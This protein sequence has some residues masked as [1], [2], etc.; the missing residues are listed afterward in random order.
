LE[1]CKIWILKNQTNIEIPRNAP[2]HHFISPNFGVSE[3]ERL[4]MAVAYFHEL[5]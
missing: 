4:F 3:L 5:I 1:E 2:T